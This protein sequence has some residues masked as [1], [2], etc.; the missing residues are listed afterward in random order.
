VLF[1]SGNFVLGRFIKDDITPLELAFFR[2]L[3]VLIIVSPVLIISYKKI[4]LVLKAKFFIVLVLAVLGITTFN[5]IL[6]VGLTMTESTNALIINSSVPI[7]ILVFSF[8]ILKQ[9]ITL[10]QTIGIGISTVGVIYLV[11]KGDILTLQTLEFNRGDIWIISASLVWALYSVLVKFRPKELN[12]YEYFATIVLVGFFVLLPIYL[13]AGYDIHH[14]IEL[15]KNNFFIFV[16]VSVFA[17][18]L[19]FYFWHY[20]ISRIGASKTGQFAHL[21]PIFGS[22]LAYIFLGEVLEAY[23]IIGMVLVFMGIYLSLFY[24]KKI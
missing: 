17:S 9:N 6:Y 3:F 4:F 12:D 19:S 15:V 7:L 16:Y 13:L 18:S 10:H 11:L 14:Q 20:G 2:W 1:W 5:T 22:I 24:K 23:H 8:F 21:M